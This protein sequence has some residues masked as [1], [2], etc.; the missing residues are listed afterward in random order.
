MPEQDSVIK[1][2]ISDLT[3]ELDHLKK[4]ADYP[5]IPFDEITPMWWTH[6][7]DGAIQAGFCEY[8]SELLRFQIIFSDQDLE[9]KIYAVC[10]P[11]EE[12]LSIEKDRMVD[13]IKLVGSG[14]SFAGDRGKWS[15]AT[16]MKGLDTKAFWDKHLDE[17]HITWKIP[18]D[19]SNNPI[20][21]IFTS[22]GH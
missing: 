21:G 22:E 20:V 8:N 3:E 6:R 18:T 14:R 2:L 16:H 9:L 11:T 17:K 4:F 5:E 15:P 19:Y 10:K 7:Y 1:A 12:Q 13:F